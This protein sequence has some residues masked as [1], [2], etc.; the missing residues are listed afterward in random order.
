M[1]GGGMPGGGH[2]G[3]FEHFG[4]FGGMANAP[5]AGHLPGTTHF[6]GA[7]LGFVPGFPAHRPAT[8]G[9]FGHG[10]GWAGGIPGHGLG[11]EGGVPGAAGHWANAHPYSWYNGHW[12]DHW[13]GNGFGGYGGGWG[14]PLGWGM[15]GW[16]MGSLWYQSGYMPYYNPYYNAAAGGWN[17]AQPIPAPAI[18]TAP[19]A[20]PP[21]PG[22]ADAANPNVDAAIE[23]FRMGEFADALVLIDGVIQAQ[24]SDAAA[25]ELRAL[26]QFAMQDYAGAAATIHAVLAIGPG[27]DW[28]TLSSIY[29][30]MRVYTGQLQALEV[31]VDDHPRQADARF[32]LAYHYLTA[33]HTDAATAQLQR[34]VSLMPDDKLAAELLRMVGGKGTAPQVA[35][36]PAPRADV[37]PVDPAALDGNWHARRDDGARFGLTLSPDTSFIWKFSQQQQ[38]QTISGNYSIDNGLLILRGT[39]G[40]AMVGQVSAADGDRFIFK[41]RGGPADDPGLTFTR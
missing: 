36:Q 31:Y 12:H 35:A 4:G 41:P 40:G 23:R 7:G 22:L 14:Y 10:A 11:W 28:T 16:G 2:G 24:P 26:I 39:S 37:P 38:T 30:D 25:H 21:A 8:V 9:G 6:P 5:M 17:Y 33:G 19:A 13:H 34:V 3:G 20:I 18:A 15:T 29:S 32:L 27:W 1:P